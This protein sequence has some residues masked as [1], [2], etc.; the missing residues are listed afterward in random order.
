MHGKLSELH[1]YVLL[2]SNHGEKVMKCRKTIG[3]ICPTVFPVFLTFSPGLEKMKNQSAVLRDFHAFKAVLSPNRWET[4]L[5]CMTT[6]WT[7]EL[8]VQHLCTAYCHK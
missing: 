3:Q 1:C 6:S 7:Q 2:V 4:F 5:E 8:R